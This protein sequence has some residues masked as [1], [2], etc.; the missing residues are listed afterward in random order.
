MKKIIVLICSLVL[1]TS[2]QNGPE[3]YSTTGEEVVM[4][5]KLITD[6]ENGDWDAWMAVYSDT[7]KVYHN[8]RTEAVGASEALKRHQQTLALMKSY[9]F[10]DDPVFF[11]KIID[12]DGET[13]VNF[14]GYWQGTLAANEELL[15]TAVH[16]SV[17]IEDGKIV[18]EHGFWDTAPLV[19]AMRKIEAINNLP[20]DQQAV[21]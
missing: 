10:M 12:D 5:K 4:V 16:L 6:Y 17:Q 11:E 13:W 15:E 9:E 21:D 20:A 2:C 18:E 3:R 1:V 8:T 19:E 7:A 14:W